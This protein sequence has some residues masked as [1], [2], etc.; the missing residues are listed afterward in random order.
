MIHYIGS[1]ARQADE[2]GLFQAPAAATKMKYIADTISKNEKLTLVSVCGVKEHKFRFMKYKK[3]KYSD[4]ETDIILPSIGAPAKFIRSMNLF[5]IWLSLFLYAVIKIKKDDIAVVYHSVFY[6]DPITLAKKIKKFK[7]VLEVEEIYSDVSG[8]NDFQKE[9]KIFHCADAFISPTKLL[10]DKVN[11]FEKPYV[12]IHGTYQV[13]T[14]RGS[15]FSDDKIHCVYAGTFDP[16]KGGAIAAAAAAGYLPDNY[17]IHVIG[18]GSKRDTGNIQKEI[19][20]LSKKKSSCQ[21]TYDGCLSGEE[22]IRYIQKCKI[23]LSTQNP[24]AAFN[25][26]SFPSKILSY[27]ANGLRVVSIRIPAIET[28]AIGK[29]LYY[30]DAQTPEEIAKAILSVDVNDNYDGRSLI[31]KLDMKFAMELDALLED[32]KNEKRIE[33]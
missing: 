9:F 31:K 8:K 20:R 12:V 15:K 7:L 14:D 13:E 22:Y 23:G 32:V 3:I 19:N 2:F 33:K 25:M 11:L 17:H 6:V 30:Y 26:T 18:F 10:L 27:M 24:E 16:R 21:V 4:N 1:F 28:S 29:R 5:I